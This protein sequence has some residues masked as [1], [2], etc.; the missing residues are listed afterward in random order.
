M[1]FKKVIAYAGNSIQT[2]NRILI[3]S[4]PRFFVQRQSMLD[5]MVSKIVD[6]L[7]SQPNHLAPY[8]QVKIDCK[9]NS[10]KIFKQPQLRKL[11]DTNLVSQIKYINLT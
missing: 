4:L 11:C 10:A 3:S 1:C 8:D 2:A 6:Y 7:K 5:V 9:I